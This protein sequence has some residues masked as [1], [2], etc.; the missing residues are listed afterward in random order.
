MIR[1]VLPLLA[2]IL[3]L[4]LLP[5]I[6]SAQQTPPHIFIGKVFDIDGGVGSVGTPVTA[7]IQ[8]EV[9]G[10]TTVQQGGKY[11]LVV[12]QGAN[13]AIT[14]KIGSLEAAETSTWEQGGATVLNLN[15][16]RMVQPR[17]IP[18]VPGPPGQMG[19][20]GPPGL[21]GIPG[22]MGPEGP[23]GQIGPKG[24]T[25]AEG[26]RAAVLAG[27]AGPPGELGPAGPAGPAAPAGIYLMI[28][29]ALILSG[30]ALSL[31]IFVAFL[32]RRD[33]LPRR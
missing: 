28:L 23:L 30:M 19:P 7:Y 26:P 25:G 12:S 6:A 27:S 31:A 29:V 32:S 5:A 21:A 14:F 24:D 3:S 4:L 1:R 2:V 22:V 17:S 15:P 16:V 20:P 9:K 10:S 13:T 33:P 8:G 11:A 18:M